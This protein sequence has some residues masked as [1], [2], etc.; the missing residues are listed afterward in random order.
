MFMLK[1]VENCSEECIKMSK[2]V[3]GWFFS[4]KTLR[5][6]VRFAGIRIDRI[7]RLIEIGRGKLTHLYQIELVLPK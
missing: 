5:V 3:H 2:N 1:N 4:G 7:C 6:I